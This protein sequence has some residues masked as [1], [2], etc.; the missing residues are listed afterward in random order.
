[1]PTLVA[2]PKASNANVYADLTTANAYHDS[3]KAYDTVWA[4]AS[5]TDKEHGLIMATRA[6][7]DLLDW[8]GLPTTETQALRAPRVGWTD[9]DGRALDEDTIPV[10]L[11]NA[12]S[13]LAKH[14]I[15]KNLLKQPLGEGIQSIKVG[16]IDIDRAITDVPGVLPNSVWMMVRGYGVLRDPNAGAVRVRLAR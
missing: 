15:E 4:D 5:N 7:D 8:F 6:L 2:T 10:F 1:M 11:E 12:T 13:E 9:R 3:V 14:F 16:P